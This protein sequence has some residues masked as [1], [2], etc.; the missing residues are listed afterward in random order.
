MGADLS[1]FK[2]GQ[3]EKE[4]S[5]GNS[6]VCVGQEPRKLVKKDD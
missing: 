5:G 6:E 1:F 4:Y 2:G 3:K